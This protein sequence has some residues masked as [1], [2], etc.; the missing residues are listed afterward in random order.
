MPFDNQIVTFEATGEFLKN[1]IEM[2]VSSSRHGLRVA[3]VKVVYSKSRENYDRITSLIIGGEP[4]QKDKI[5]RISTTDFLMQGNAGL[6]MLTKV[7]ESDITRYE[8]SLRDIIVDFIKFNSPVSAEI[9]DRWIRDDKAGKTFVL[10]T[11]LNK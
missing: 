11:E 6:A 3:G 9:D 4:W 2:R 8:L 7:P 5:Y 10:E 1:V